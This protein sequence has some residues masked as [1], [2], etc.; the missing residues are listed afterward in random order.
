MTSL[1]TI[2][3]RTLTFLSP[4]E[5]A[6]LDDCMIDLPLS[7]APQT[8]DELHAWVQHHLG[9]TIP[10]LACCEG[11]S[12]PFDAFA[13][14]YFA[15]GSMSVWLASRGLGGKS[16]QLAALALTTAATLGVETIVLGG[17]G[18]QS[19]NVVKYI[20]KM[21]GHPNF[22]AELFVN[23][24]GGPRRSRAR[25]S[26]GLTKARIMLSNGGSILALKAS[27]TATRG[28]HP[29][30]LF[31]DEVD[32]MSLK[33]LDAAMGQ[34]MER[35]GVPA[36]TVLSSTHHYPDGTFTEVLARAEAQ[37]WTRRTWCYHENL[38][39]HGWL[40][41]A[42]VDRKR[43]E[44]TAAMFDAEYDLQEPSPEGRA[45]DTAAVE[46]M[47][48]PAL[49]KFEGANGEFIQLEDIDPTADYVTGTDWGKTR[50]WSIIGTYRVVSREPIQLRLVAWQRMGRGPWPWMIGQHNA[51][52]AA[53]GGVAL[54]D[55]G[56]VGGV[57]EDYMVT[58]AAD[59]AGGVFLSGQLR[60]TIFT[61]YVVA[62]EAGRIHCPR[63][64]YAYKEHRYLKRTDL[65]LAGSQ[66]HPPDS[67]VSGALA[68]HAAR[69][70]AGE[71]WEVYD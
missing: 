62:C 19:E 22:P 29:V 68:Y 61:S 47:F 42:E 5:R 4:E 54:H 63:I 60:H 11:H 36:H 49:G 65:F 6:E 30:R 69:L 55:L 14:A 9:I 27:T 59:L 17:S 15:R 56:G 64:N 23:P 52:V 39:P 32:E 21:V 41:P 48:D 2:T 44:V 16:F 70:G 43:R 38:Q 35:G 12:A 71:K 53:Y 20:D 7:L 18:D 57:V 24:E 66:H 1:P 10:R 58:E 28:P 3:P 50:D 33:V 31:C 67:F 8:D 13:D 51:R 37:G 46:A 26:A 40:T 45:I 25:G 34:T